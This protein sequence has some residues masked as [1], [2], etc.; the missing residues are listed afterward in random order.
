MKEKS[1]SASSEMIDIEI[2]ESLVKETLMT[3][4]STNFHDDFVWIFFIIPFILFFICPKLNHAHYIRYETKNLSTKA[5]DNE[6]LLNFNIT[7]LSPS[8]IFV[9]MNVILF[10]PSSNTS[11]GANL[12]TCNGKIIFSSEP[13]AQKFYHS[14]SD[15]SSFIRQ[16]PSSNISFLVLPNGIQTKRVQLFHFFPINYTNISVVLNIQFPKSFSQ[17]KFSIQTASSFYIWALIGIHF[18]CFNIYSIILVMLI[19]RLKNLSVK[20]WHLEQKITIPFLIFGILFNNPFCIFMIL[21]KSFNHFYP[22]LYIFSFVLFTCYFRFYV[23]SLLD[24]LRYKNRNIN[25]F[26]FLP[27]FLFSFVQI[28]FYFLSINFSQAFK[29]DS[30][31]IPNSRF[32]NLH[33]F[34]E[35]LNYI[36]FFVFLFIAIIEIGFV[37]FQVDITE[38]HKSYLYICCSV[39]ALLYDMINEI[40]VHSQKNIHTTPLP[41]FF[42]ILVKNLFLILVSYFHW[43]YEVF[44]D[45]QYDNNNNLVLSSDTDFL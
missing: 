32:L 24:S 35:L 5:M 43:P 28:V 2:E 14:F 44:Q 18:L 19:F 41:F 36:L 13:N 34:F 42:S 9:D 12:A 4:D 3:I 40:L 15:I 23:I 33:K 10:G 6:F 30:Y 45:Q 26:F 38:K 29:N 16:V 39:Y 17:A 1:L 22:F 37:S 27:K 20:F 25:S 11:N 31:F 21:T 7:D 8:S